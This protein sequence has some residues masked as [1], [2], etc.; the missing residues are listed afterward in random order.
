[1]RERDRQ[2]EGEEGGRR[3]GFYPS[4]AEQDHHAHWQN[5][6]FSVLFSNKHLFYIQLHEQRF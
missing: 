6:R 4:P 3:Y 1:M 2:R 5:K